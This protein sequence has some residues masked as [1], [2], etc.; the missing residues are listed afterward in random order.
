MS[1]YSISLDT[2][3]V[4]GAENLQVLSALHEKGQAKFYRDGPEGWLPP[5]VSD[6]ISRR[7]RRAACVGG[8]LFD[9][10]LMWVQTSGTPLGILHSKGIHWWTDG[11]THYRTLTLDA[12]GSRRHAMMRFNLQNTR[13]WFPSWSC[14]YCSLGTK[15]WK[16]HCLYFKQQG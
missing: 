1:H 6:K 10:V 5:S 3:P 8:S 14:T 12:A 11:I 7:A 16:P 9:V 4:A 15:I 2:I 13:V